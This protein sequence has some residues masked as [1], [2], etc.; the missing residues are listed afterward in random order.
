MGLEVGDKVV[1]SVSDRWTPGIPKKKFGIVDKINSSSTYILFEKSGHTIRFLNKKNKRMTTN[2]FN[3]RYTIL[4]SEEEFDRMVE[5]IIERNDLV[6]KVSG[7]ITQV[8]LDGLRE[9][10]KLL[11]MEGIV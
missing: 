10:S 5:E 6:A 4:D 11:E 7:R 1:L 2:D 3:S 8:S 9:I